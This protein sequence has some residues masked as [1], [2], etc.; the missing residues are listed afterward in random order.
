[1]NL[2]RPIVAALVAAGVLSVGSGCTP[3]AVPTSPAAPAVTAAAAPPGASAAGGSDQG[4][5]SGALDACAIATADDVSTAV[6][7]P[8]KQTSVGP[9]PF[10]SYGNADVTQQLIVHIYQD[11]ASLQQTVLPLEA[12]S[13][14]LDGL[15]DDAFYNVTL[16]IIFVRK[17][18]RSV[19]LSAGPSVT[20]V[21]AR[22]AG[23]IQLATTAA[24]KL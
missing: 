12:Q 3:P 23:M 24:S 1:V 7:T 5:V 4:P 21:A 17:G 19:T 20:D 10:C 22:R 18:D 13:E 8:M 2:Q 16:G 11:Q 9:A 14:H 15:G 6:G